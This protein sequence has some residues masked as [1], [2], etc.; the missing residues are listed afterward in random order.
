MKIRR[1]WILCLACFLL[2]TGCAQQEVGEVSSEIP[3]SQ[4]STNSVAKKPVESI[5]DLH[6]VDRDVLYA[7]ADDV[8]IVTMYLTVRQGNEAENTKHFWKEVSYDFSVYD[9]ERMGVPRYQVLG[10][11]QVGDENGPIP[12]E[13]GYNAK[14]PNATVRIRGQ[15]SS[16]GKQKSFKIKIKDGKGAWREQTTIALNKHINDMTRYRN[17]LAYDLMI[18]IPGMMS[19]RTQFV[20]LY[21][22]DQT[23]PGHE[24]DTFTDYGLF[25]QVEQVNK[26]YLRN[27]NLD[28]NGQLYKINFF[29][30]HEYDS[31]RLKSDPDYDTEEFGEYLEIKGNEDHEKL[32]EMLKDVNDYAIPIEDIFE[33]WFDEEN[34]FSWLAFHI[35]VGNND[36]QSRNVYIYSPLNGMKWYFI[37]WDNDVSFSRTQYELTGYQE[38]GAYEVGVS[39]YWGNVLFQRILKSEKYRKVLDDKVNE[40]YHILTA[41]KIKSRIDFYEPI[42][43]PYLSNMP[44]IENLSG[45]PELR[46]QVS[47]SIP[48]EVETNYQLYKES[49]KKPMPFYIGVPAV[50]KSADE[51]FYNWDASF[52]FSEEDITYTVDVARD[53]K[54]TDIVFSEKN[55]KLPSATSRLFSP[56]QYFVRVTATNESGYEQVAFDYYVV[57]GDGKYYGMKAFFI[58][59]DNQLLEEVYT[60]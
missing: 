32:I 23:V 49:L 54:F 51:L 12:G 40:I 44:D 47:K 46:A 8:P 59:E 16:R 31:I 21:V 55:L 56:G 18:D 5:N 27:H 14:T 57:D 17:K 41:E 37:S 50:E 43:D 4:T 7:N 1:R 20:H 53:Y 11:L 35:L 9:Y 38:G 60:E 22:K 6:L 33:K 10:L 30:F 3:A 52:D 28:R 29:E 36:T 34:L 39:N 15:T 48:S 13:F 24:E 42:I 26:T 25:T 2:L 19:A 58:T 45:T